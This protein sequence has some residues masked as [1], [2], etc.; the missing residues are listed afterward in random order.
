[1]LKIDIIEP[2]HEIQ[3]VNNL[4]DFQKDMLLNRELFYNTYYEIW[5]D[6]KNG[7]TFYFFIK[8]L[9]KVIFYKLG[10]NYW[11]DFQELSKKAI[12]I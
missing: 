1:M 6:I 7:K 8:T 2:N 4:S 10:I 11:N 3:F 12:C 5:K 9:A